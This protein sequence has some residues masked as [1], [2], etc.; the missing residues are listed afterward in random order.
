MKG[1]V[2]DHGGVFDS[3]EERREERR[4]RRRSGGARRRSKGRAGAAVKGI[5]GPRIAMVAQYSRSKKATIEADGGHNHRAGRGEGGE[6]LGSKGGG[7]EREKY[8]GMLV[9]LVQSIDVLLL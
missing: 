2:G 5:K 1:G 7:A 8:K 4:G 6:G 9:D 3:R